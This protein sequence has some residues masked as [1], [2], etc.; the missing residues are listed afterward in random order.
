MNPH[1][2]ERGLLLDRSVLRQGQGA[3]CFE[4]CNEICYKMWGNFN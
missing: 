2:I 1:D 3:G 4:H